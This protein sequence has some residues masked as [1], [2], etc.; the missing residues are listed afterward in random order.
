MTY[1]TVFEQRIRRAA[2]LTSKDIVKF[3]VASRASIPE[4]AAMW[5][6]FRDVEGVQITSS[7]IDE[8]GE[9]QTKDLGNLWTRIEREITAADTL[10]LYARAAD[11]P[12]KGALTE[13]GIALGKGKPVT[14][15]L[16]DVELDARSFR[17]V[18]SWIAHP[19][20]IRNDDIRAAL[21]LK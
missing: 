3:Y 21:N 6:K 2:A 17:P 15:C 8:D 14:V 20:V 11:F 7:W 9:G 16:P 5:R 19:L 10:V 18:G 1:P 4:R 13:A 12:L